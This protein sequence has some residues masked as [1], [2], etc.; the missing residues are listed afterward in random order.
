[1]PSPERSA[2]FQA[3]H[4]GADGGRGDEKGIGGLLEGPTACGTQLEDLQAYSGWVI[5]TALSRHA[6]YSGVFD[7]NLLSEKS[8]FLLKLVDRGPKP[9]ARVAAFG[10][11]TAGVD[12]RVLG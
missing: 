2:L 7:A 3:V 5:G 10:C 12:G 1:M 8:D 9:N 6:G 11:S 4:P